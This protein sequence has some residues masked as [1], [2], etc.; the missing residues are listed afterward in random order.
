[1]LDII[2][3]PFAGDKDGS[4]MKKHIA[5]L[6]ERL[7]S[8]N[9]E[10]TLHKTERHGH[11]KELTK[12]LIENG[13]TD[14][15]AMGGDGTLNEVINGFD[16]FEK[17]NFG[18][19]PCG[20]GNDFA[21]SAKIPEDI[22]KAVD[23]IAK[24]NAKP[25][26]FIEFSNGVRGINI[27]GMGID[28]DILKDY[29]S[30]E[31]K[32]KLSYAKCLLARLFKMKLFKFTVEIDG[33]EKTFN[34]VVADVANGR[35]Y[36]GG[37]AVC[38]VAEISDGELDFVTVSDIP[39]RTLPKMFLKLKKGKL[40]KQKFTTHIKGKHIKITTETPMTV[41]VDGELYDNLPF[42]VKIVSNKLKMY[43]P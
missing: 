6:T 28:V 36:G 24:G 17:V 41:N 23:I 11:A 13:A 9:I 15:I 37:L 32:T 1:M 39:K 5:V 30:L 3:N 29:D 40:L 26:D 38:P 25:T 14:V 7:E 22:V 27:V 18:L 19:I 4:L 8:L 43:R 35:E 16:N 10:F 21:T 33:V 12:T 20:T 31:H 34:S 2:F 42:D